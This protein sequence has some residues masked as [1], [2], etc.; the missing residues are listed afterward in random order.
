MATSYPEF[1]EA[2]YREYLEEASFL[3]SY[4]LSLLAATDVAW[5]DIE[6]TEGRFEAFLDGLVVGG[7]QAMDCALA[8]ANAGDAGELH[9][10]LRVLCRLGRL[11]QLALTVQNQDASE[12]ARIDA[13]ADAI[14]QEEAISPLGLASLLPQLF[15][16]GTEGAVRVAARVA[17]FC[18]AGMGEQWPTLLHDECP[19]ELAWAIGRLGLV[20]AGPALVRR[21]KAANPPEQWAIGIALMRL[22]DPTLQPAPA[23]TL[24]PLVKALAGDEAMVTALAQGL[25]ATPTDPMLALALGLLGEIGAVEPLLATLPKNAAAATALALLLGKTPPAMQLQDTED[26][27]PGIRVELPEP[28]AEHNDSDGHDHDA[29]DAP[30]DDSADAWPGPTSEPLPEQLLDPTLPCDRAAWTELWQQARPRFSPHQRYRRGVPL[31]PLL[32]V[33]DLTADHHGDAWRRLAYEELVIRYRLP[34]A[35]ETDM[36]VAS[37][38]RALADMQAWALANAKD[39]APGGFYFA[40]A[41]SKRTP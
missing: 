3:Y 30:Q 19:V 29:A 27:V 14:L 35:F 18:R 5:R 40:G 32:L 17:G 25:Q 16:A 15:A 38:E 7:R 6:A 12:Q 34:I 21:L 22:G 31:T 13:A 23:W 36:T 20:E 9:A 11:D 37:Q 39:I 10:A 28:A 41:P 1:L 4:R 2:L 26:T 24:P 8:R 33:A